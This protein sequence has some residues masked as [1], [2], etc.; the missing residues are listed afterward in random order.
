MIMF[1]NWWKS[2]VYQPK[3]A[4]LHLK[5]PQWQLNPRYISTMCVIKWTLPSQ[6]NQNNGRGRWVKWVTNDCNVHKVR[7]VWEGN[8]ALPWI[9]EREMSLWWNHLHFS[10]LQCDLSWNSGQWANMGG[11]IWAIGVFKHPCTLE[12]STPTREIID[13][14]MC[15]KLGC[16]L[17]LAVGWDAVRH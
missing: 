4:A 7:E 15:W 11:I 2:G 10:L 3:S 12:I 17:C 9:D 1:P 6:E 13:E 8:A 16:D 5:L 14:M